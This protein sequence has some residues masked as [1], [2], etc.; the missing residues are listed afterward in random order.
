MKTEKTKKELIILISG[1]AI[2]AGLLVMRS[3][4]PEVKTVDM[5]P[6]PEDMLSLPGPTGVETE[7]AKIEQNIE[8]VKE[9]K[10]TGRQNKDPIDN[11][12]LFPEE[13]QKP[14]AEPSK[15][16]VAD[17]PVDKFKITAVLWGS[18]RPQAIINDNV[19]GIGE[20][21]DGGKITGID[22][23]GIHVSYEGKE[24]L[25]QLK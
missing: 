17:F 4:K 23:E 20:D 16:K 15:P 14:A 22:K 11:S 12:Y 2:L 5:F 24:V 13:P 25:L 19:M 1:V 8:A 9:I 18:K 10:Y 21:L 6:V 3:H 7:P